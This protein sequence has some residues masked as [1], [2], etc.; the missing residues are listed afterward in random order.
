MMCIIDRIQLLCL[1][2]ILILYSPHESIKL[3]PNPNGEPY[4]MFRH[5]KP[6]YVLLNDTSWHMIPDRYTMNCLGWYNFHEIQHAN[7][8]FFDSKI[9]GDNIGTLWDTHNNTAILKLIHNEKSIVSETYGVFHKLLNPSMVIW[10]NDLLLSGRWLD[11]HP[12]YQHIYWLRKQ[13][14]G[15]NANYTDNIEGAI[16]QVGKLVL[17]I[18]SDIFPYGNIFGEDPRLFVMSNGHIFVIICH[19]FHRKV[20]ELQMA[21]SELMLSI[22]ETTGKSM[23]LVGPMIDLKLEEYPKDDQKNWS[24]FEYNHSLYFIST[25]QPHRIVKTINNIESISNWYMNDKNVTN[26][27]EFNEINMDLNIVSGEDN[28]R[29]IVTNAKIVCSTTLN[30]FK[31]RYGDMRGGTPAVSIGNNLLLTFFHS[32]NDPP[33]TGKVLKTYVFGAYI[34]ENKPP[35]AIQAISQ[36]PIVHESMYSGPWAHLPNS[37]YHIDYIAFPMSFIIENDST[38]YLLYGKQDADAWIAKI[39]LKTLLDSLISVDT[40]VLINSF[41]KD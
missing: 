17:N 39:E 37:F 32:S 6:V 35:F 25:I 19:R 5:G 27:S 9:K 26:N 31:W 10:K 3:Y 38:I 1:Y 29:S 16:K 28:K 21:Y 40:S 36:Q 41:I 34:F 11:D 2:C 30:D 13:L 15:I 20:P 24:P 33:S 4:P 7:K 8:S 22:N 23:V 14:H 18:T 12:K